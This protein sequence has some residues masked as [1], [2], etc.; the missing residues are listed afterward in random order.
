MGESLRGF[1]VE[2]GRRQSWISP[3]WHADTHLSHFA[4][5]R[6]QE[7]LTEPSRSLPM[8]EEAQGPWR[9]QVLGKLSPVRN[10]QKEA[11]RGK[12]RVWACVFSFERTIIVIR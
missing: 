11:E 10:D 4:C 6:D 7:A 5:R 8:S 2:L 1:G 12:D 9:I 3:A